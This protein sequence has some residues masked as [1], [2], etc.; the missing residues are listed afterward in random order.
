MLQVL[1][2]T[3]ESLDQVSSCSHKG[4][5][6]PKNARI[7]FNKPIW[8]LN[9]QIQITDRATPEISEGR[10]KVALMSPEAFNV[11]FNKI[12]ISKDKKML[13]GTLKIV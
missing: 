11:L 8:G 13:I 2:I 5:F 6:K 10:K 3:R 4:P 7:V 1:M 12:A 9:I